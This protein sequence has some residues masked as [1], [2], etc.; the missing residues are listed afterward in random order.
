MKKVN[1]GNVDLATDRLE[2]IKADTLF[3]GLLSSQQLEEIQQRR[4]KKEKIKSKKTGVKS[5]VKDVTP[6]EYVAKGQGFDDNGNPI[7][8]F[9]ITKYMNDAEDP[10]TGTLRDFNVDTRQLAHAK[11]FYDFTMNILASDAPMYS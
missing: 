10:A 5:K 3:P 9:D 11:N 1:Y 7:D 8:D 6:D 4:I 2:K